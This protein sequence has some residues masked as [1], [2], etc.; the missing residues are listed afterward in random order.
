M[1]IL[2]SVWPLAAA[3]CHHWNALWS[4]CSIPWPW[5]KHWR[6]REQPPYGT[7]TSCSDS[8]KSKWNKNQIDK[9]FNISLPLLYIYIHIL[10]HAMPNMSCKWC[11]ENLPGYSK[12]YL[13]PPVAETPVAIKPYLC[14]SQLGNRCVDKTTFMF[15]LFRLIFDHLIRVY[16]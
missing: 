9:L 1:L 12:S 6:C 4:S 15:P 7:N 10:Q 11:S 8:R 2:D 16:M 3:A 14:T 5:L 13:A